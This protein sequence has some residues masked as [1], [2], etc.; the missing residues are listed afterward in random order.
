MDDRK[1]NPDHNKFPDNFYKYWSLILISFLY[2]CSVS[3]LISYFTGSLVNEKRFILFFLI[4]TGILS[5]IHSFKYL[6]TFS[7][8]EPGG[9]HS[10]YLQILFIGLSI[11]A[12]LSGYT[13][14]I[15]TASAAGLLVL[16]FTDISF[17]LKRERMISFFHGGQTLLTGLIMISFL[18][19]L[20]IP[21]LFITAIK[22]LSGIYYLIKFK[23]DSSVS[24]IRFLRIMLLLISGFCIVTGIAYPD[25]LI[26]FIFFCGELIERILYYYD[27]GYS[28]SDNRYGMKN[29]QNET[30]GN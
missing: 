4:F 11:I 23:A 14:F 20:I 30:E 27:S 5:G 7:H 22:L 24:G 8:I 19:N 21:F 3:L 18:S 13:G 17:P 12:V 10:L 28:H 15:I 26:I 2:S 25:R 9:I 29:V 16:I 6:K 1:V